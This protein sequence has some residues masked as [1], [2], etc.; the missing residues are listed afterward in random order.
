MHN[1]PNSLTSAPQT[2]YGITNGWKAGKYSSTLIQLVLE[3]IE[4]YSWIFQ[5]AFH[6]DVLFLTPKMTARSAL[7]RLRLY[8]ICSVVQGNNPAHC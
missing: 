4:I 8:K 5:Q 1:T 2:T 7:W 3:F 6:E